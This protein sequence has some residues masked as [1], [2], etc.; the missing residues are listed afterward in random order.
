MKPRLI[1]GQ[2][3]KRG[4]VAPSALHKFEPRVGAAHVLSPFPARVPFRA[5]DVLVVFRPWRASVFPQ[6][7]LRSYPHSPIIGG[8]IGVYLLYQVANSVHVGLA[9]CLIFV[10]RRPVECLGVDFSEGFPQLDEANRVFVTL[11]P[12][13]LTLEDRY[14]GGDTRVLEPLLHLRLDDRDDPEI[15]QEELLEP[16]S[17]LGI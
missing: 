13:W 10:A 9:C 5:I 1:S 4:H 15:A 11:C 17:V 14:S 16:E 12:V 3:L 6:L 7:S 2:L 8:L